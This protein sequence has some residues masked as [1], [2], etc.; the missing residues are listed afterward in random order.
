VDK[1]NKKLPHP[2]HWQR[3]YEERKVTAPGLFNVKRSFVKPLLANVTD[4][5]NLPDVRNLP[6]T[7][8]AGCSLNSENK[9]SG[10]KSHLPKNDTEESQS[11]SDESDQE[12]VLSPDEYGL[13]GQTLTQSNATKTKAR[14]VKANKSS[15]GD[16]DDDG[17]KD[18]DYYKGEK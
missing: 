11:N 8:K 4:K 16:F 5:H 17:T 12:S 10:M 18:I 14:E 13:D 15:Q 9:T 6:S 7:S 1:H 3:E 2:I